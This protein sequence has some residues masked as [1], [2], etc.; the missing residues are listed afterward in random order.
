MY[1]EYT[2]FLDVAS[3]FEKATKLPIHIMNINQYSKVY[4]IDFPVGASALLWQCSILSEAEINFLIDWAHFLYTLILSLE[5]EFRSSKKDE[6]G[7]HGAAKQGII[8]N[9]MCLQMPR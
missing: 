8:P 2:G 4:I 7:K 1:Q 5:L 9:R 6:G 3:R